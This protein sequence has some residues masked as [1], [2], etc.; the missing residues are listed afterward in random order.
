MQYREVIEKLKS[1]KNLRNAKGMAR[2]GIN[3]KAKVYGV[4]MPE[5]RKMAKEIGKDHEL[6][7]KLFDSGIHEA[8][9]L[10]TIIADREKLTDEQME[11]WIRAFDS[12]DIVDQCCM[13]LLDKLELKII[14]KKI[15][16]WAK[17][18]EEFVRRTAFSLIAAFAFH[19]KKSDDKVFE[20]YFPLIKKYSTDERNFVRKAANWALRGIGKRNKNLNKE[21]I[22]LAKEIR[23]L[24]EN[25]NSKSAKWIANNA[26][27]ELTSK[28]YQSKLK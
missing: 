20:K 22:K 17:C 26:L 12:W 28:K 13:N 14:N 7:I 3:P 21:A 24:G 5:L 10:A 27:A 11:K 4:S 18:D 15:F 1:M 9:I 2:F 8:Q 19:D 16:E 25:Q 23:E 6:A